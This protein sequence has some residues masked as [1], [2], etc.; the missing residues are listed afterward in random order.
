VP[1][2]RASLAYMSTMIFAIAFVLPWFAKPPPEVQQAISQ[3]SGAII[4]QW[5]GVMGYYF[6]TSQGSSAKDTTLSRMTGK[7]PDA[8]T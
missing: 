3:Y 4:L 5:G 8:G 7:L 6:G 1:D 2:T